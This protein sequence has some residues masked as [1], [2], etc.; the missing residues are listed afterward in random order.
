LLVALYVA[1]HLKFAFGL[2]GFHWWETVHLTSFKQKFYDTLLN[3][4]VPYAR[5]AISIDER[6]ADFQRVPWGNRASDLGARAGVARFVQLWFAGNHADIGGGYPEAEARLSDIALKW[7]A[8]EA[9]ALGDESLKIDASVLGLSPAS[10]GKQ[11][12]ATRSLLFRLA[13]TSD[14]RL[15]SKAVTHASVA[16]RF[17]IASPGVLQHDVTALYRPE[18][19]RR[20]PQFSDYYRDVP[21]PYMT[22]RQRLRRQYRRRRGLDL[23]ETEDGT[24][25]SER[26][27]SCLGLVC[28]LLGVL[29]GGGIVVGQSIHWL[30]TGLWTSLPLD[31]A[32]GGVLRSI[33]AGW[34]GLQIIFAWILKLPLAL[35][36][37][38][39]GL[40][41]FW[42]LGAIAAEQYRKR[43]G[44]TTPDQTL[45]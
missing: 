11:H 37:L 29:G 4:N 34:V 28:L 8:D 17:A 10:D 42:G 7:M 33:G 31:H 24:M 45:A 40:F 36:L 44:K 35:V 27:L 9:T 19:L 14:R 41:L 6:R 30:M 25:S 23:H 26:T 13:G 3:P 16:E 12:D 18:P 39:V 20:H 32:L 5:H 22:C 15:V 2:P 43:I 38:L 21:L 1:T